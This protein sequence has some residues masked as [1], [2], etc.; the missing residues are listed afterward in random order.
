MALLDVWEAKLRGVMG[1]LFGIG[2]PGG[3]NLKNSSGL[4]I[5]RDD[6][7]NDDAGLEAGSL[8]VKDSGSANA[9]I[10]NAP[11]LSGNNTITLPDADGSPGEFLTTNGS[12]VWSWSA[13]SSNADITDETAFTEADDGTLAMF[14]LPAG[15]VIHSVRVVVDTAAGGGSPTISIGVSGTV[16]KYMATT[17]NSL[18]NAAIYETRPEIKEGSSIAIIA[19]ISAS[20]QT[21]VGRIYVTY[22]VPA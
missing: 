5:V 11:S 12:G 16:D 2:G 13:S 6:T 7:D 15:A 9:V 3:V 19:T 20:S 14:T 17:D 22:G 18:K 8:R 10:F 21:F 1:N 4:L